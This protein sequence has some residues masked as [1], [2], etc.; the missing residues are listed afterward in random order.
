MK[1]KVIDVIVRSLLVRITDFQLQ[2]SDDKLFHKLEDLRDI[3]IKWG[4]DE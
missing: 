4:E 3:L 2:T 1:T